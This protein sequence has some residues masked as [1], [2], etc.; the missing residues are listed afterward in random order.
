MNKQNRLP[1][2]GNK[3]ICTVDSHLGIVFTLNEINDG[4]YHLSSPVDEFHHHYGDGCDKSDFWN[5][6]KE[7]ESELPIIGKSYGIINLQDGE[8]ITIF[9]IHPNQKE[10]SWYLT[11]NKK[12]TSLND[13]DFIPYSEFWGLCRELLNQDR[14]SE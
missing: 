8:G 6:F 9:D 5:Y 7:L 10:V 2:I 4:A 3:Y 13:C 11:K 1:K 14:G 12:P